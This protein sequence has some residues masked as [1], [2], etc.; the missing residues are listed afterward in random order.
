MYYWAGYFEQQKT[1]GR[2][3]SEK[4]YFH[5][6]KFTTIMRTVLIPAHFKDYNDTDLLDTAF[7]W[8][9]PPSSLSSF[10]GKKINTSA[11]EDQSSL[12]T[13]LNFGNLLR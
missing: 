13:R 8:C 9:H 1:D 12:R 7:A 6:I 3:G 10:K 5:H 11:C 4:K 2:L